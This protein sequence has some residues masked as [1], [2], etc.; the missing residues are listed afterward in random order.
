[1]EAVIKKANIVSL[2]KWTFRLNRYPRYIVDIFCNTIFKALLQ[3]KRCAIG[4]DVW[5]N[6]IPIFTT[7]P[8]SSIIIGNNVLLCSRSAN[9]AL[10]VNHPIIMRTMKP[11]ATITIGNS[12]RMS[13][14]SICAAGS[15]KIGNNAVIGANA[16]ITDTDFHSMDINERKSRIKEVDLGHA[17]CSPVEVEADV[18]VGANSAILKGVKVGRGTVIGF[19]SV[20]TKSVSPFSIIAGNP[21][22]IVGDISDKKGQIVP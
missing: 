4:K 13:G 15:V 7:A 16:V 8:K 12:V 2:I 20:V 3:R 17:G 10:G 6:G 19:G 14:A 1:M 11:G 18:F 21:A 9:T 5:F 22:R